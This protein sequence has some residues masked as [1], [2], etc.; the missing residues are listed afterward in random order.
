MSHGDWGISL[1]AAAA[2]L[3][4]TLL[5]VGAPAL[6]FLVPVLIAVFGLSMVGK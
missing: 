6:A 3:G 4:I 2:L 5:F 1:V